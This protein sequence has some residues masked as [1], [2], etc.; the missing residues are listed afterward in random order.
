ETNI[1]DGSVLHT[2]P[3]SPLVLGRNVTVGHMAMLHG[4]I[5]GDHTVIGI[6]AVVLNGA[7][8]GSNCLIAAKAMVREN[9]EIP[10]NSMVVGIPGRVLRQVS[11]EMSA[12]FAEQNQWYVTNRAR[13]K[14][15]LRPQDD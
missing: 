12:F 4:C 13:F 9:A 3:G 8:I 7:K 5:V 6:G 1:Q 2:D 15:S 14:E 11:P 10:D